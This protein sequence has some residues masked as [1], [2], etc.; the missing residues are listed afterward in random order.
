MLVVTIV[1]FV[2]ALNERWLN[3]TILWNSCDNRC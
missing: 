1:D 2:S 3:Y